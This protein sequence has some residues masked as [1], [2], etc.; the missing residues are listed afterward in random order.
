M[1]IGCFAL[2]CSESNRFLFAVYERNFRGADPVE[3]LQ[4]LLLASN[5]QIDAV[6]AAM[7]GWPLNVVLIEVTE[8]QVSIQS[9]AFVTCPIYIGA[10]DGKIFGHWDAV[11][12]SRKLPNKIPNV[13]EIAA[14]MSS[15]IRYS[16]ASFIEGI[17]HLTERTVVNFDW[18][19]IRLESPPDVKYIQPKII[20]SG[21]DVVAA[22]DEVLCGSVSQWSSPEYTALG[23]E[24]SG[25]MDS[26]CVALSLRKEWQKDISTFSILLEEG[27]AGKQQRVRRDELIQ[28]IGAV[29]HT[30]IGSDFLPMSRN[31]SCAPNEEIYLEALKAETELAVETQTRII[32]TGIGGDELTKLSY[33]E[34][35]EVFGNG[36][37]E[38][39]RHDFFLLADDLRPVQNA[40]N[41]LAP[42]AVLPV[43]TL[44]AAAA[45]AP[46]FLR[47]GIWVA[48]P[49]ASPEVYSFARS[50]PLE[51]RRDRLINRKHLEKYGMTYSFC[52]PKL[53]EN[54]GGLFQNSIG[55]ISAAGKTHMQNSWLIEKKIVERE[56]LKAAFAACDGMDIAAASAA[57]QILCFVRLERFLSLISRDI[58]VEN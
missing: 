7:T 12:A 42:T 43:S 48:H 9:G 13:S 51:W 21:A 19:G 35:T 4:A 27:D 18:R 2:G 53:K 25:G 40:D 44:L 16:S 39:P 54:F 36:R 37:E 28:K 33:T 30:V 3:D 17:S 50:L 15:E 58:F 14:F 11:V 49:L 52:Y 8:S 57:Q 46:S 45:R 32:F 34:Y 47:R 41:F 1:A 20:R 5:S 22:F 55:N 6:K 29:D 38:R 56:K 10:D 23:V 24:A 26:S 31:L